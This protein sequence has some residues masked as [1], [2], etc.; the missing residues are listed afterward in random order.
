[1]QPGTF[2]NRSIV[3]NIEQ[4]QVRDDG[5]IRLAVVA[6]THSIP[7]IQALGILRV[8]QPDAIVH[9]GDVGEIKILHELG[10]ICPVY[11]VGGNIDPKLPELPDV[12]LLDILSGERL[13]IRIL[14]LHVGVY[15]PKLR[16]EVARM[17]RE[18]AAS[19]V[20]CGHSHVPFIGSDRGFTIFNPGSMGPRRQNLPIVF[21][22]LSVTGSDF[23]LHH[24]DCETGLRWIPPR[25]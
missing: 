20:I 2:K 19:V 5:S 10:T 3:R 9:A 17:A 25:W 24:I 22:I 23:R 16:A 1:M 11:A 13:V 6:D 14:V 8:Q 12:L 18:E 7:H 4:I 15:G 21:G